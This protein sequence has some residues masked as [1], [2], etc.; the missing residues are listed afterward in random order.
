MRQGDG[1]AETI[2]KSYAY[3]YNCCKNLLDHERLRVNRERIAEKGNPKGGRKGDPS[4][5]YAAAMA[6]GK[7]KGKG[8][9][10]SQSRERGPCYEFL[11]ALSARTATSHMKSLRR[12]P[13]RVRVSRSPRRE[14]DRRSA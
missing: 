1:Q 4:T 8:K 6:Q 7:G 5:A 14:P 2:I 12:R 10:K 9:S 13:E 11:S 3:L